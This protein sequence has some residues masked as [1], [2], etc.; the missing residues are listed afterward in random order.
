MRAA[1]SFFSGVCVRWPVHRSLYKCHL[2][3]LKLLLP[4]IG[5]DSH[6]TKSDLCASRHSPQ[7]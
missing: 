7:G 4:R 6:Y 3:K 1:A 2:N 5:D